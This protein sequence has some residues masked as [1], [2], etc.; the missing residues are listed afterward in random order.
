MLRLLRDIRFIFY[1]V[2]IAVVIAGL[3]LVE[4]AFELNGKSLVE[5]LGEFLLDVP[6]F[7]VVTLVLSTLAHW[8][9]GQLN[10]HLPWETAQ[11]RR[12]ILEIVTIIFLVAF[13]TF[14]SNALVTMTGW[15]EEELG[16]EDNLDFEVLATI[17]Y[18][19]TMFMVFAYHEFRSIT[20]DRQKLKHRARDLERENLISRYEVL[21]NQVN[22]HF[23]FNSLNVLSSLI[24]KD[25]KQSDEF[26]RRFSQVF[27]YVLDLTKDQL[28]T[29]KQELQFID[30]YIFLQKT[31]HQN[32]LFIHRNIEAEA[33][34][35]CLPPMALQ[36]VVENALKH[37]VLS[38]ENP[39]NL[40]LL[41]DGTSLVVKNSFHAR[42][43][44][45]ST[46]VGQRNLLE[47]YR[48]LGKALPE[49]YLEDGHYVAR[50]P[51]LNPKTH[52]IGHLDH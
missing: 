19:I 1:H 22:P 2:F 8:V 50:L 9:I 10:R 41:T 36:I 26:I 15:M 11:F 34:A 30:A 38:K 14:S 6:V 35:Q 27:R 3:L 16:Q 43:S 47:R 33:M 20:E 25:T 28:V 29:L 51:L 4:D 42:I 13:F 46:G 32:S 23:L 44:R 49:F 12:F 31:R 7:L 37:N 40:Y 24:Y 48:L 45:N 17:M 52:E 5:V 18:F 21:R 39:L